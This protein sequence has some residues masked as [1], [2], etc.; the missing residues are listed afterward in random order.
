[1]AFVTTVLLEHGD[2]QMTKKDVEVG[3]KAV[4]LRDLQELL[5]TTFKY[6]FPR[7][8]A[9][10]TV[11]GTT[12]DE[13]FSQPFAKGVPDEPCVVAFFPSDDPFFYDLRDRKMRPPRDELS[14]RPA[15]A[16]PALD[17]GTTLLLG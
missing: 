2:K 6:P 3:D 17:D 13:F 8:M 12:H 7:M 5:C 16:F 10:L 9:S 14:P 1:M 15:P 11:C 4:R